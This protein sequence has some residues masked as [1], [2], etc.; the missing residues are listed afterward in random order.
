[1]ERMHPEDLRALVAAMFNSQQPHPSA[2]TN[3]AI[4][5]ADDLLKEL[6]TAKPDRRE[7][8]PGE[9]DKAMLINHLEAMTSRAEKAET[10]VKE[11]ELQVQDRAPWIT[12]DEYIEARARWG[13]ATQQ[14]KAEAAEEERQRIAARIY[15]SPTLRLQIQDSEAGWVTAHAATRIH[16]LLEP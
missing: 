5:L 4:R 15:A 7:P 12:V 13:V 8:K 6:R 3:R 2:S 16:A 11:L 9:V 1:M 10:R 14:A